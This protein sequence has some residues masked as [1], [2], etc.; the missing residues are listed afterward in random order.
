MNLSLYT[1]FV[2]MKRPL[3][4]MAENLWKLVRYFGEDVKCRVL[5]QGK[6]MALLGITGVRHD[7]WYLLCLLLVD[8]IIKS[9]ID[10]IKK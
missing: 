9:T 1:G 5:C 6:L 8:L 2:A 10:T 4:A 3:T 7:I